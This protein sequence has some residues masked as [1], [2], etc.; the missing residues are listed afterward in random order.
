V[1][2]ISAGKSVNELMIFEKVEYFCDEM[3][4]TERCTFSE[5]WLQTVKGPTVT[6]KNIQWYR[7]CLMI[8]NV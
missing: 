2:Y 4:I 6:C 7:Y 8:W 5:G 3:K 1:V